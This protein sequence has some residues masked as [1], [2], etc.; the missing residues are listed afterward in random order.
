M[1]DIKTIQKY[2]PQHLWKY[3]LKFDI[4]EE[5]LEEDPEL[6]TLILESKAIDTDEEKQNWL[7]LL[8]LM[9]EQQISKLREILLKERKKLQEIEEKYEKK[10]LE[11]KKKYLMKWQKMWYIKKIKEIQSKEAEEKAKEEEE[12]EKILEML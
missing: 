1:A 5:F 11:I 7:N 2:L 4:P 10:K 9:T 8:L 12:A 3:A 6:I